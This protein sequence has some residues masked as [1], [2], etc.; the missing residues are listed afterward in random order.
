MRGLQ[1]DAVDA[2]DPRCVNY[3]ECWGLWRWIDS[4]HSENFFEKFNRKKRS[5][6]F[7]VIDHAYKIQHTND[8]LLNSLLKIDDMLI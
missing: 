5:D 8:L 2:R 7:N 4:Y 1:R 6:A 3:L